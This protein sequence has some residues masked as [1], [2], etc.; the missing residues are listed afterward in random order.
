MIAAGADPLVKNNDGETLLHFIARS[1]CEVPVE[2]GSHTIPAIPAEKV[3]HALIEK[4]AD[5]HAHSETSGTPLQA[6]I[7]YGNAAMA[8]ALI[9]AGA[10]PAT[11]EVVSVD[12]RSDPDTLLAFAVEYGFLDCVD[13]LIENGV[14]VRE[15]DVKRAKKLRKKKFPSKE[16]R[17][18][19]YDLVAASE[20]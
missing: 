3:V 19:V 20:K 15:D 11:T 16:I 2:L 13:L 17:Q 5:I 4:G 1:S 8:E 14:E 6:A 18:A 7:V 9:N 12:K 10:N